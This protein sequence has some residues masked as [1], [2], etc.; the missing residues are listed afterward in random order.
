MKVGD[1][2]DFQRKCA[3]SGGTKLIRCGSVVVARIKDHEIRP[4]PEYCFHVWTDAWSEVFRQARRVRAQVPVRAPNQ[5]A[6][7]AERKEKLDYRG[8]EG[9]YPLRCGAHVDRVTEVVECRSA[10]RFAFCAGD[11]GDGGD[12]ETAETQMA[13]S[14]EENARN[15]KAPLETLW[16]PPAPPPRF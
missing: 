2:I 15:V 5:P 16:T 9:D 7:R 6:T 13:P 4:Q 12:C 8:I 3:D 1:V 11:Q 10:D 14:S